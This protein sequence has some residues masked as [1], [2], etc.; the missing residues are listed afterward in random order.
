LGGFDMTNDRQDLDKSLIQVI[1]DSG[2]LDLAE[3][4]AEGQLDIMLADGPLKD[5]PFFGTLVKLWKAGPQ[6]RDWIFAR[7]LGRFLKPFATLPEKERK[8]FAQ[9]FDE[10][11]DE[12]KRLGEHLM[13]VLD[14]LDD[15]DK[16]ELLARAFLA[17]LRGSYDFETLRRLSL[18]IE[19]CFHP[20][21]LALQPKG[22]P[23]EYSQT[24]ALNLAACG[25]VEIA[26][27]P[28]IR[29]AGAQNQYATTDLGDTFL[30]VV[31]RR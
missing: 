4:L 25:L 3:S 12:R 16:P 24:T 26:A 10:H 28:S 17:Y 1:A 30:R 15:L 29:G 2:V 23:T 20:D 5:V 11:P 8:Q 6:I 18:A 27:V 22:P 14:R 7:K 9:K 13:I 31:L 19:R 21:L